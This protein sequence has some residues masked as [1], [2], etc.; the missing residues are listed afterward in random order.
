MSDKLKAVPDIPV[1]LTTM[2]A[3]TPIPSDKT[4]PVFDYPEPLSMPAVDIPHEMLV[5]M[6]YNLQVE[7]QAL[8]ARLNAVEANRMWKIPA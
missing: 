2:G 8:K 6:F 7:V 3:D 4:H 5:L 1:D